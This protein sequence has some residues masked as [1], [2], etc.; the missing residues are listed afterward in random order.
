MTSHTD[1]NVN[2]LEMPLYSGLLKNDKRFKYNSDSKVAIYTK[3][4]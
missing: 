4:F 2:A 3:Y 1:R